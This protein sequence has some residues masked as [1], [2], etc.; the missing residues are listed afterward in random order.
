MPI[1]ITV[2]VS[3]AKKGK[4]P[5]TPHPIDPKKKSFLNSVLIICNL[6]FKDKKVK[7]NNIKKT[8]VHLQKASEI[9]GTN[10]TPPLATIRLLAIN[11]GWM[12]NNDNGRKLLFKFFKKFFDYSLSKKAS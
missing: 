7:G 9:G 2:V 10:S 5:Q 1:F 6:F 11:I 12:N 8:K 3:P 4:A